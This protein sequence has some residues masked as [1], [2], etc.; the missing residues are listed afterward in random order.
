[1]FPIPYFYE[2]LNR[3]AILVRPKQPF[4]DW[5]NETFH[6]E[7]SF[8]PP[9]EHNIYLVRDMI[10]NEAVAAWVQQHWDDIFINEL[11]DWHTDSARWPHERT[12]R[13]FREWFDIEIHSTVLDLEEFPIT[14]E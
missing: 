2:S 3:N 8:P 9:T 11:N 13:M 10:N 5:L 6:N 14:K 7:P 4:V 1:M 12:Y